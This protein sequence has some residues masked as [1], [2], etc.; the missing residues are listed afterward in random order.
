MYN[1]RDDRD[2]EDRD[3]AFVVSPLDD[4]YGEDISDAEVVE[5]A[6]PK[7]I[8]GGLGQQQKGKCYPCKV[9]QEDLY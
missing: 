7:S 1:C 9:H 5:K 4:N 6:K 3:E 2:A 8:E